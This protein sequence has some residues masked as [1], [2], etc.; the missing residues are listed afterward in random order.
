MAHRVVVIGGGFGGLEVCKALR[1]ADVEVELIDRRNHHLFQPLL[2]QVATAALAPSD[3]AVPL[4]GVV[5]EARNVS[6]RLGE[7]TAIDLEGRTVAA[8]DS[9]LTVSVRTITRTLGTE[10]NW[11]GD[12]VRVPRA[13]IARV[14][15]RHVDALRTGLIAGGLIGA[16]I[17]IGVTQLIAALSL[18]HDARAADGTSAHPSREA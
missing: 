11:N 6:V 18:R 13:A 2:Y 9:T 7:V 3:I 15:R 12:A 5:G 17:L 8:D 14:E 1:G 16:A 10:E 4:R